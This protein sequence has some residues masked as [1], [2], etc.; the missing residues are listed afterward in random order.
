LVKS[1]LQVKNEVLKVEGPICSYLNLIR[2]LFVI[3][4]SYSGTYV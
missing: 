1:E 2:D 3:I 4:K